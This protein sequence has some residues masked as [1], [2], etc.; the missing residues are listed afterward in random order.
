M[1][2]LGFMTVGQIKKA[3]SENSNFP[4]FPTGTY[5]LE[6][7]KADLAASR[8]KGTPGLHL[9]FKILS[10]PNNSVEYRGKNASEDLWLTEKAMGIFNQFVAACGVSKGDDE[11]YDTDD[12]V[13]KVIQAV[14]T[15]KTYTKDDG[16]TGE[17]TEWGSFKAIKSGN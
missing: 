8:K 16:T 12:F 13:G 9:I 6:I 4:V 7:T 17:G 14:G 11:F 3:A 15:K 2:A 1:S 10:G 5:Q